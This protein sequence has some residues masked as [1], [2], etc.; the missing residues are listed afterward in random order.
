MTPVELPIDAELN[1]V[2]KSDILT[3]HVVRTGKNAA[4]IGIAALQ[5]A[6]WSRSSMESSP[7]SKTHS[8]PADNSSPTGR[9]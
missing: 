4:T 3:V 5:H 2:A 9:P 8:S 7:G 6:R 1:T